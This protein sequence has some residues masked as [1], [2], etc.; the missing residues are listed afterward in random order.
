MCVEVLQPLLHK[1][2]STGSNILQGFGGKGKE[3][4]KCNKTFWLKITK[5]GNI[6][7][8]IYHIVM[9]RK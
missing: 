5:P 9:I 7:R 2:Y 8:G 6:Y 1:G 3:I 4:G